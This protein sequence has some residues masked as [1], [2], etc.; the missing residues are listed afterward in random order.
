MYPMRSQ[1]WSFFQKLGAAAQAA[2]SNGKKTRSD[3]TSPT[4]SRSIFNPLFLF[5]KDT[6]KKLRPKSANDPDSML[7]RYTFLTA[8]C[9]TMAFLLFKMIKKK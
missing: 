3:L 8:T 5:T 1:I 6:N 7:L 4:S 2:T 9:L